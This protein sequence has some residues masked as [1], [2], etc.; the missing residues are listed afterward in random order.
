MKTIKRLL[1]LN[2]VF[3]L[4]FLPVA[5][6][7][8]KPQPENPTDQESIL[9]GR[10]SH[11][12]GELLRYVPEEDA[13]VATVKDEPFYNDDLL[14]TEQ[15]GRAELI[16]PN[17]T[18]VRMNHD[19]QVQLQTLRDDLTEIDVAFGLVRCHNK[20]AYAVIKA[21]T[22]FGYVTAPKETSFDLY[23]GPDS[24]EVI[25]LKGSLDFFHNI[26]GTRFEVIAGE[27]AIL[28][29]SQ[30]V[31]SAP[32]E[33]DPDWDAWNRDREYLWATRGR[34]GEA[35]ETYLPSGLRY[36]AYALEEYGRWER[37]YYDGSYVDCWRP[38]YVSAGWA[39]FT[40]GRW[41]VYYG[42]HV[43]IPS[44]P[45]GYVTHHY[46]NW[47]FIRG[48][49]YWAPPVARIR[50][51]IGP[52]LLEIG[53][54]W[55]PG[56]VAWVYSGVYIGW[57]PLAPYEPYYCHRHWGPH[58]VVVKNVNIR[59]I[60][61]NK[62]TYIK[63]AVVINKT[64]LYNVKNY[65]KVRIGNDN[66][67]ILA[68]KYRVTPVVN[69]RVVRN[70]KSK[71][72]RPP[73]KSVHA[74]QKPG[75]SPADRIQQ[76][77]AAPGQHVP[78]KVKTARPTVPDARRSTRIKTSNVPRSKSKKT[79]T[80]SNR[81][82]RRVQ[83]SSPGKSEYKRK[84]DT[85]TQARLHPGKKTQIIRTGRPVTSARPQ[86]DTRRKLQSPR[87]TKTVRSV[88]S[89]P[90][91]PE[92]PRTAV[93]KAPNVQRRAPSAPVRQQKVKTQNRTEVKAQRQEN[94]RVS[95]IAP[96]SQ[97]D[98]QGQGRQTSRA[99]SKGA[100][101]TPQYRQ[102]QPQQHNNRRSAAQSRNAK[103]RGF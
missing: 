26:S 7:H 29:D 55:Y 100:T 40:A 74:Q 83:R 98:S 96:R 69:N 52:P 64:N 78:T 34:L 81:L 32:G 75:R 6:S 60:D 5:P 54:A 13:W 61:I 50:V 90:T 84:P 33:A 57:V 25:A 22:P 95:R 67:G 72:Q 9:V 89:Q 21:S 31:T 93:R 38:V 58:T 82:D 12:E 70:Y 66:H 47:V 8:A 80:R 14:R 36:E 24:V 49:W 27:T 79:L 99:L 15:K 65:T 45:F 63:H 51:R 91:R 88:R 87:T 102:A 39:P 30:Q 44:E 37:V 20:G 16:L 48:F 92:R 73:V 23:V 3:S 18:W 97:P 4:I 85:G 56:R 19:T 10:I 101:K 62:Y 42:D 59:N 77:R 86:V 43:W 1:W 71:S 53:F 103:K 41:S 76:R 46:G 2:I 17:N 94:K 35:S 28:A 11:V 68:R